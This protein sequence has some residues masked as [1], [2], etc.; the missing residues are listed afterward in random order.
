MTKYIAAIAVVFCF[1]FAKANS[2]TAVSK[3]SSSFFQ[4]FISHQ[5]N[6]GE[7]VKDIAK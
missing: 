4:K 5:V 1:A 6:G 7:T 3:A 2:T